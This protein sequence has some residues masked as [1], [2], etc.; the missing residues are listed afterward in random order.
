MMKGLSGA[1]SRVLSR[2]LRLWE[3]PH[4]SLLSYRREAPSDKQTRAK[5]RRRLA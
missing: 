5:F 4:P 2:E 1:R 3:L